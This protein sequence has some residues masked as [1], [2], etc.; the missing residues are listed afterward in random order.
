VHFKAVV[1]KKEEQQTFPVDVQPRIYS[2]NILRKCILE[3]EKSVDELI[4]KILGKGNPSL[5]SIVGGRDSGDN[6]Q[7]G[8]HTLDASSDASEKNSWLSTSSCPP[9][10]PLMV[11]ME[12]KSTSE[13][14][15]DENRENCDLVNFGA[16]GHG[17]RDIQKVNE[18]HYEEHRI[19][20]GFLKKK[21][22]LQL[23][24]NT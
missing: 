9:V 14:E 23:K 17:E 12:R 4:T 1:E 13:N 16:Q 10:G 8:E 24:M 21:E 3:E 6:I 7:A 22:Q 19:K 11:V 20:M 15:Q 2:W 5:A 18:E